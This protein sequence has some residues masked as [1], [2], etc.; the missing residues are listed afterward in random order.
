VVLESMMIHIIITVMFSCVIQ[1]VIT[2]DLIAQAAQ[3]QSLT[4]VFRLPKWQPQAVA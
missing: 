2:I 3:A 1:I 4:N